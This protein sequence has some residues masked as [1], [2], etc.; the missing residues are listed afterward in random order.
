M[1]YDLA[2]MRAQEEYD[3]WVK[4]RKGKKG[5]T[6]YAVRSNKLEAADATLQG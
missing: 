3:A 5:I 1:Q 2:M 6:V 4:S